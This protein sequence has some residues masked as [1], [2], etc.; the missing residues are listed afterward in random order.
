MQ[1]LL[2]ADGQ[3]VKAIDTAAAVYDTMLGINTGRRASPL[4]SA[5]VDAAIRVHDRAEH[6]EPADR[7]QQRP[8]RTDGMA[9]STAMTPGQGDQ[10]EQ[11]NTR[12]H[13][14]PC[15]WLLHLC[16]HHHRQPIVSFTDVH[17]T[18]PSIGYRYRKQIIED[19]PKD[20]VRLGQLEQE[21]ISR[22]QGQSCQQQDNVAQAAPFACKRE[23]TA[24]FPTPS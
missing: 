14:C 12:Q 11:V 24:L 22:E 6:T 1:R 7:A 19:A 2:W 4:A 13:R 5:T 8:H 23:R 17:E 21:R 18:V 10:H 3:A 20:A 15:S 16:L 9:V